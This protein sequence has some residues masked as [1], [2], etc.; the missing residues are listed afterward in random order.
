MEHYIAYVANQIRLPDG[1][2]IQISLNATLRRA[3]IDEIDLADTRLVAPARDI[4]I[5]IGSY[6]HQY[7]I[8]KNDSS[9]QFVPTLLPQ[10]QWRYH[11]LEFRGNGLEF[12]R[13]RRA[14]VIVEPPIYIAFTTIKGVESSLNAVQAI[15]THV[16]ERA[17]NLYWSDPN[18]QLVNVEQIRLNCEAHAELLD[19]GQEFKF[20]ADAV[21]K[22]FDLQKLP[23]A[24]D[25]YLLGLFSIIESLIAHKPRLTENL[26]SIN[27]QLASKLS[28][29]EEC[30]INTPILTTDYFDGIGHAKAWRKLYEFR[31][32]L[33]HTSSS[34]LPQSHLALKSKEVILRFINAKT[35]E[36]IRFAIAQ[37][38]ILH[39]LKEC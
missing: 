12:L 35:K 27:H 16:L 11:V 18:G 19:K 25:M 2:P 1:L 22:Y 26:D 23:P 6:R 30:F 39:H 9:S 14:L 8:I 20:G 38:K 10:E 37:P 28:L 33:A 13:L 34:S 7:E 24:S 21:E 17:E 4:S 3:N 5:Q 15:Q 36:L 31:S 29:L 32:Q